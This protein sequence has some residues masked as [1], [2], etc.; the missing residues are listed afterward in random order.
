MGKNMNKLPMHYDHALLNETDVYHFKEGT[1]YQL[2]DKLGAT[3]TTRDG[4]EGVYFAVWA[5][6]AKYLSVIGEF[7]DWDKGAHP[8]YYR[9]DGS[10]VW[11]CF[12]EGVP[13]GSLY[14]Y[15]LESHYH[16]YAEEKSDPYA[17]YWEEPP[18]SATRTWK[19]DYEWQDKEWMQHRAGKNGIH[20]PISIYEVHL[21]SWKRVPEEEGRSL[22]YREIAH[23][24]A[25][26]VSWL[27]FTHVELLPITE[28]PY[29]GSWGYQTIGYFAPTSR[30]GTPQDFMYFIDV[31][32]EHGIGVILDWVPS[33]F[34]VDM[35]GL[36]QF[37]GSNLY[38]HGDPRQGFHPEWGSC[39]FNLGRHEVRNFLI[40]S[41]LFW[42]EKYHIDGIRV[43]AV[44]SM[45]YLDYAREDGEWVA[46]EYG[47]KENL[48]SINFLQTLNHNVYERYPDVMMI[49]E[50]STDWPAV[51]KP[52]YVGGLGFEFKWN[53]GWMHDTLKYLSRDPIFRKYHHDQITFSI[54]YAFHEQ[55]ML[56]LSH[57]EV[58]HMKGSLINKMPGDYWQKFA[59]VRTLYAYMF[60][61]PGKK[62]LFMGAELGQFSEW[63]YES[64]LDWHLVENP[65][66]QCLLHFMKNLHDI[67]KSHPA[68]WAWDHRQDGFDWVDLSD[69][70]QSVLAFIRRGEYP[71]D[72]V[73]VVCNFTPE[74]RWNYKVGVPFHCY[75]EEI[76]NTDSG[77]Y[78][79]SNVG[80]CGGF[81]SDIMPNHGYGVSLNLNLPPLGVVWMKPHL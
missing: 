80:N 59:N 71:E 29:H 14:K 75:W 57:D 47:G 44:A 41:A 66:H 30:F 25:E 34:A 76:L 56:S 18:R 69:H 74:P 39:I 27:G 55:Y 28:H 22:N 7:N 9:E 36:A 62:L 61:H 81:H 23:Q 8:M 58:V 20:A 33:H 52:T 79:G 45:L 48:E 26:Y 78:G 21:G 13:E 65:L 15:W 51:T 70:E 16:G 50:E 19:L 32:H 67:Y 40:S 24:L 17:F 3:Y 4:K 5:P 54:W 6:H 2:Y 46:N 60:A 64:S 42:M 43:D 37:D 12:I 63:N 35:H 68:L 77:E 1:H 31:M 11:D 49:A 73:L 10:G 38:E 72:T 53:M